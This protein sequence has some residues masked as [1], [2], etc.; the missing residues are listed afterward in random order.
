MSKAWAKGST[1]AWRRIRVDVL[2]RDRY[3]CRL[4]LAGC[5]TIADQVHHTVPR[6]VVGDD[7]EYL[8]A[9]CRH[10]NLKAGNPQR[11]EPAPRPTTAWGP[12]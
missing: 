7:P 11:H 1:S 4:Q 2:G 5:T 6:T 9:A 8:V 12:R 10:C 3:R